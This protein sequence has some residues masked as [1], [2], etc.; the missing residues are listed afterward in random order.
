[1]RRKIGRVFFA[2]VLLV[3]LGLLLYPV[4]TNIAYQLGAYDAVSTYDEAVDRFSEEELARMWDEA[5]AYNEELGNPEVRDPFG[6]DEVVP[7]LDRYYSVLNPDGT[8]MM[9]YVEVP[10]IN[11][12]LPFY[13]GTS[14]EVLERGAG[15]IPTSALPIDGTSIHP[16]LTGHTGLAD[17]LLFTNLSL[18]K[19]GDIVRIRVLDKAFSYRVTSIAIIEPDDTSLLQPV[20]GERLLTLFTCTPY[21]INSHRLLVTGEPTTEDGATEDGVP[22]WA[23]WLA[24]G[25]LAALC[26]G[27]VLAAVFRGRSSH[28][29][30]WTVALAVLIALALVLL[31]LSIGLA[32]LA[33][34]LPY[35][36]W[37]YG[38][39]R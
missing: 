31:W 3:G 25:L 10:S 9:G 15:H 4:V 37:G 38:F 28:R 22:V 13:H 35:F 27:I 29:V 33:G 14:D 36:D 30:T 5:Y 8:G 18:V 26:L 6:Y 17:K 2:L 12:Y 39:L 20:E 16:I 11:L 7:P 34:F 21:G 23:L 32:M 1:M 19:N 24:L